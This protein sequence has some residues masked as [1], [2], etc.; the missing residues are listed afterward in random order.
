[1]K[2]WI[3]LSYYIHI[4]LPLTLL[5]FLMLRCMCKNY[6]VS[7]RLC[8]FHYCFCRKRSIA[9]LR[10]S[11]IFVRATYG[12]PWLYCTHLI[13]ANCLHRAICPTSIHRIFAPI[14]YHLFSY[15]KVLYIAKCEN[16][17]TFIRTIHGAS[18]F[19]IQAINRTLL[20]RVYVITMTAIHCLCLS[21]IQ[22][23]ISHSRSKIWKYHHTSSL[24]GLYTWCSIHFLT[25]P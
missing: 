24:S 6:R 2:K 17:E 13:F 25:S 14:L 9:L 18:L 20:G 3:G 19:F 1:M 23:T 5:A 11:C 4:T 15:H 10:F 22:Y 8:L 21:H 16:F 7:F 12:T